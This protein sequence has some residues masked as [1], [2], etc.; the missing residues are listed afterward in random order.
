MKNV[1][2]IGSG[3]MGNG[4]AHVFA[5]H[6]YAVTLVDIQDSALQKA[7][8]TIE[9]NLTRQV[10]KG[11]IDASMKAGAL[12]NITTTTSISSG[13]SKADIVVEAASEQLDIKLN[14][15]KELDASAPGHAI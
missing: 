1:T 6:Q 7:V 14:I 3:T 13:C 5:L 12:A 2:V 15:F 9:K 10:D 11:L 8:A 4:I